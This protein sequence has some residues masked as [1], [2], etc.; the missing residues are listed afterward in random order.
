MAQPECDEVQIVENT[1][2]ADFTTLKLGGTARYL[3][4]CNSIAQIQSALRC[5][6]R[7]GIR[8][9]VLGGGSNTIFPDEGFDGLVVKIAVRGIRFERERN[10]ARLMVAA[11]EEWDAFVR[12]CIEKKLAGV[13]CLSGI[14]GLVGAT[15][16][17]NVGAYGQ[18]V[19]ESIV[20]VNAIERESQRERTFTN[21]ECRFAYRA[22][23]FNTDDANRFVITAVTFR[24]KEFGE[25]AIRYPELE[26]LLAATIAA[27]T[28][29]AGRV[30]LQT[31]RDAVL[32]LRKNKSMVIDAADPNSRSVG[33][34]FK[35]PL[36]TKIEFDAF[37]KE[38][39]ASGISGSIPTFVA[40]EK[41][42]VPAAWLVENA[43]FQKGFRQNGVGVSTN[44][45]LALINIDG[46]TRELLALA[47]KIR[48]TV[49]EKFGVR[50]EREPVVVE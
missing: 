5:A 3:V 22:S 41:V 28:I 20:T 43:G 29:R 9:H 12:F 37:E 4:E 32:T 40:G 50:L 1:R 16:I 2:L 18:E 36:L 11:G 17:Q 30:R 23:R 31:A 13:E 10:D 45:S 15:P 27:A 19:A 14:P 33:S 48:S 7:N 26:R 35:N 42:K 6:Q 25:P 46:T 8:V 47:S 49:F 39:R 38:C 34:F 21:A 44:H 24:L